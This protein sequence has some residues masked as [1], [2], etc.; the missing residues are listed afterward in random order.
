MA[1]Y[2]R[3]MAELPKEPPAWEGPTL[4]L[5]GDRDPLYSAAVADE[6]RRWLPAAE[7]RA[8]PGGQHFHPVERPWFFADALAEWLGARV[9]EAVAS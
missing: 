8:I 5:W 2:L 4:L 3:S 9:S 1:R 7:H 6:A